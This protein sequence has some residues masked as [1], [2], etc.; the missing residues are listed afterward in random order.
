MDF[1]Q[2][3]LDLSLYTLSHK[4]KDFIH[5]HIVDAYT[6]QTVDEQTKPIALVYALAGLYLHLV[7]NYS[8]RQVQLAHIEMSKKNK[9]FDKII[10]PENRGQITV[11]DV[12]GAPEG[13]QRDDMIHKWC[14]SVW[15]AYSN[16]HNKVVEM[17]MSI[18]QKLK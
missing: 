11:V 6:A 9:V 5:Q 10:L 14:I 17:T 8:G 13:F 16:E 2:T 18:L 12:L 15:D 1:N 7:K 3:Y 4:S